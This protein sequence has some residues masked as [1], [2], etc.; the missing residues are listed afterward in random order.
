M[1]Q[2]AIAIGSPLGE[3]TDSVT[4][5]IISALGRSIQVETGMLSNLI[6]TDTAINP[7]NSGGPLLDPTGAVIGINTAVAGSSQGI[8]FAIPINIAR[9]LLDQASAGQALA[10]PWLGIRFQTITPAIKKEA[11]LPVDNGAWIPSA[12][13][14]SGQGS[15]GQDPNAQ[16][17]QGVDPFDPFGQGQD[18]FGQGG[19][20]MAAQEPIVAGGPA[21]QAGLQ[22]GDIITGVNGTALDATHPLDLVMSQSA[23]GQTITL[24]VLR[25]GQTSQV[26]V[27]LGTRPATL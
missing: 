21:E 11:N 24:D 14:L 1:G 22:A 19:G 4:S 15:T 9:P 26:S 25:N 23:P 20:A 3:F 16:G 27:T 7:G 6:Q 17:G 12:S 8:G 2:Q 10:R 5:G 18:P 13:A